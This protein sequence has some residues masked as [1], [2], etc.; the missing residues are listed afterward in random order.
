MFYMQ[1]VLVGSLTQRDCGTIASISVTMSPRTGADVEK[2]S[3]E[4][5]DDCQR[6]YWLREQFRYVV[7]CN[8]R[9]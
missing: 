4:Y 9:S 3:R 6:A 5:D 2:I 8:C 7:K 1:R